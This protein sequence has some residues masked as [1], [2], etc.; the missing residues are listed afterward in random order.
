MATDPS[1]S[2]AAAEYRGLRFVLEEIN[3]LLALRQSVVTETVFANHS[4]LRLMQRARLNGYLVELLFVGLP[5]VDDSLA[6]VAIRVAK[7]GHNVRETD[8]RRRWPLAHENLAKAVAI[9]DNVTVYVNSS[10]SG[11]P[12]IIAFANLGH[13]TIVDRNA[14]PAVTAVL[15]PLC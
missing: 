8:I 14:L 7:G 12:K 3:R 13:V 10:L 2:L 1:L 15:A 9:A 4:Y 6:R 11:P 5:S